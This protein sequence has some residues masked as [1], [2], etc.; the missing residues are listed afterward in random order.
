[1]SPTTV[2]G[3]DLPRWRR[4]LVVL[5]HP[6]EQE[7][8]ALLSLAVS[9]LTP[10][11]GR[12]TLVHAPAPDGSPPMYWSPE[13]YQLLLTAAME[14]GERLLARASRALTP[15]DIA[16]QTVLLDGTQPLRRHLLALLG[17]G[18]QHDAV[19]LAE[20]DRRGRRSRRSVADELHLR[21]SVPVITVSTACAV[22]ASR[23]RTRS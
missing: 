18:T 17:P 14:D 19:L 15:D 10:H 22:P 20:P 1:M 5:R 6:D 13:S 7:M 4:P 12:L 16:V 2:S 21:T 8:W 11:D 9:R 23:S 3:S